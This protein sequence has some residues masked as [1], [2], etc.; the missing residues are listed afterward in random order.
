MIRDPSSPNLSSGT[1]DPEA[2][3]AGEKPFDYCARDTNVPPNTAF[4]ISSFDAPS[5]TEKPFEDDK[6]ETDYKTEEDEKDQGRNAEVAEMS[7]NDIESEAKTD[8]IGDKDEAEDNEDEEDQ[9][10]KVEAAGGNNNDL[11]KMLKQKM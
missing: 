2:P 5:S 10:S 11:L 9:G 3:L 8:E 4:R 7:D 1:D 6:D